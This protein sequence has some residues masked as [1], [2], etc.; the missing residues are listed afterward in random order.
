[1]KKATIIILV[2]TLMFLLLSCN[3]E[4]PNKSETESD[5]DAFSESSE[6]SVDTTSP[7]NSVE[8]NSHDNTAS[9]DIS[10]DIPD[11]PGIGGGEDI[12]DE[13]FQYGNGLSY[14][15]PAAR[16]GIEE[17]VEIMPYNKMKE[18]RDWIEELPI[19]KEREAPSLY[20]AIQYLNISKED[21][22]KH[23]EALKAYELPYYE[24]P[25]ID[26]LYSDKETM[27]KACK[28]PTSL[29]HKGKVY[30]LRELTESKMLELME[31]GLTIE[32]LEEHYNVVNNFFEKYSR[33]TSLMY[34]VNDRIKTMEKYINATNPV[35]TLYLYGNEL[36]YIY[37]SF[38]ELTCLIESEEYAEFM[39]MYQKL[40]E[41]EK[42][43][44]P[45]LYQ[46]IQFSKMSKEEFTEQQNDRRMYQL[47]YLEQSVIDALYSDRETML[48]ACKMPTSLYHKGKVYTLRELDEN[49][50]NELMAAGLSSEMLGE[51]INSAKSFYENNKQIR[52]SEYYNTVIELISNVENRRV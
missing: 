38:G 5:K 34:V 24:Q 2:I 45:I 32:E 21:F 9:D 4:E 16:N 27:L 6:V 52:N 50:I 47:S 13:Y 15:Y 35:D 31:D 36:F 19:E 1:M 33:E 22:M 48:K 7:E 29:Y 20:Y 49:K 39:K 51:Y 37:P 14:I 30:T 26:A 8:E 25:V 28:M 44:T 17:I 23:Q 18:F 12:I 11:N 40:S 46:A 41:K 43:E 10:E 3:N 42:R